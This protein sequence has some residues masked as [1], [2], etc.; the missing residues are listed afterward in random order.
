MLMMIFLDSLLLRIF[1]FLSVVDQK[2]NKIQKKQQYFSLV[3]FSL[4][5]RVFDSFNF[6][7][8]CCFHFGFR[9]EVQTKWKKYFSQW[10]HMHVAMCKQS[11][12]KRKM[13]PHMNKKKKQ[14]IKCGS[15]KLRENKRKKEMKTTKRQI[16]SAAHS[17]WYLNR[18]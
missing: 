11:E 18:F 15:K 4:L 10:N 6:C 13:H 14:I 1:F 3:V 8:Y 5:F 16:V 12:T 7:C 17:D 9:T 2:A